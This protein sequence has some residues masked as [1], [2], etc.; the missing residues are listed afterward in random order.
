MIDL[1][2]NCKT[3]NIQDIFDIQDI[4]YSNF[5]NIAAV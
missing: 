2:T 3:I 1:L 5:G 4:A